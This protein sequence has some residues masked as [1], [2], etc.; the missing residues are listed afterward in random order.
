M[1]LMLP[2][3]FNLVP[4]AIIALQVLLRAQYA[5]KDFTALKA[6]ICLYRVQE[7]TMEAQQACL[8]PPAPASVQQV[9]IVTWSKT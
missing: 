2:R 1:R 5:R 3:K 7:D 9:S 8:P 6:Q 4:L